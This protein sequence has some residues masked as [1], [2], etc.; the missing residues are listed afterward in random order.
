LDVE[1]K[2]LL[3]KTVANIKW[4]ST[5]KALVKCADG[6]EYQADHVIFT[7]SLGVLKKNHEKLFTPQLPQKKVKAIESSGF[8]TLG[9]IFLEFDKPFWPAD[10]ADWVGYTFLW[11][12][13]D[14]QKVRG[15]DREW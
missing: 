7:A 9:K 2:V 5:E 1:S 15:T 13:E 3:N 8:G 6:S 14:L 4:N 11:K 12:A 10:V